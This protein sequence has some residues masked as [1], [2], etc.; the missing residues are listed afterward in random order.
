MFILVIY[1]YTICFDEVTIVSS[2]LRSPSTREI[3]RWK[4]GEK[5][6]NSTWLKCPVGGLKAS[7]NDIRDE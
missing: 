3:A 1:N 5:I 6:A 2:N 7:R 4:I